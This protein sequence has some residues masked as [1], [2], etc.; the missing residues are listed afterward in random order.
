MNIILISWCTI[1]TIVLLCK[2][3]RVSCT[4]PNQSLKNTSDPNNSQPVSSQNNEPPPK[5]PDSANLSQSSNVTLIT[6]NIDLTESTDQVVYEHDTVNKA[7]RWTCKEGFLIE[8][9]T[10]E[11]NVVW[12]DDVRPGDRVVIRETEDGLK[13]KVYRPGDIEGSSSKAHA[14]QP[15]SSTPAPETAAQP[16]STTPTPPVATPAPKPTEATPV[17]QASAATPKPAAPAQPVAQPVS[18]TPVTKPVAQPVESTPGSQVSATVPT[19]TEVSASQSVSTKQAGHSSPTLITVAFELRESTNQIN[20]EFDADNKAHRLKCKDGFLIEKVTK[21]AN[22]VWQDDVRPGD[23][24][25]IRETEDG[26]KAKVYRPG[27]IE[28]SSSKAHAQQ[29]GSSTPAPETAAQPVSTTPTPPVATP[30]PKP[31][32]ATPVAQASAATPKPAPEPAQAVSTQVATP[33]Q[34]DQVALPKPV[35]QPTAQAGPVVPSPQPVS[36]TP[37]SSTPATKPAE[38]TPVSQAKPVVSTPAA[39][40]VPGTPEAGQESSQTAGS[41]HLITVN[42]DL[43]ESTDQVV[44]EHD[45]VNK[46]QRWTCKEGFLIEKVTK[47]GNVVWQP[48]D[49][50]HG[51]RV[52]IRDTDKGPKAKVYRPGETEAQ[53]QQPGS[54]TPAPE[55]AAQPV[56]TTPTP[57]VAT[58]APK[59]TEATPVAQASAATP[60]PAAPAQPVAQPVSSTPVTKPVAQPVESTPGSQVSATVPTK[61]EVSASQSVST[62]QA[63]HSSPT[64]ITVAF[65]LRE[66]TNQINYEFDA[67][68]KAHRLKCKDGFLIEKV[69]KEANVVWQDDVRPGDRVVI[70]ETEDGLKA[71]VYRPGDIEGSSSKA[72]ARQVST[73]TATPKEPDQP[74]SSTPTP[75]VATPAPKPTEATPV[76]QASAATPKPAPEPA[77]AVST[78]VAT[79]KQPDQVALPKPVAQPTAQAGPVVPSPQPVSTTP[80][81][82]TPATKPA[83]ATP[84]SQAKPVVSTPAAKPVPGTPEA[85]QEAS[86]TIPDT[87]DQTKDKEPEQSSVTP[88]AKEPSKSVPATPKPAVS[89]QSV[90]TPS[91]SM[92][93]LFSPDPEDFVEQ[94]ASPSPKPESSTPEAKQLSQQPSE[95]PKAKEPDTSGTTPKSEADVSVPSPSGVSSKSEAVD[96]K[97]DPKSASE[98]APEQSLSQQP[99]SQV[100][101]ELA[102]PHEETKPVAQP[103]QPSEESKSVALPKEEPKSLT[104]P[105]AETKSVSEPVSTTPTAKPADKPA[106]VTPKP[107]ESSPTPLSSPSET[108]ETKESS[109]KPEAKETK[110]SAET[111]K[112]DKPPT[113]ETVKKESDS[114]AQASTE[115]SQSGVSQGFLSTGSQPAPSSPDVKSVIVSPK[116]AEYVTK[117]VSSTHDTKESVST[118][119]MSQSAV[120][121][122][123][124]D[125]IPISTTPAKPTEES[126]SET[127][128][129]EDLKPAIKPVAQASVITPKPV[130]PAS[131][132]TPKPVTPASVITPKPETPASVITPKPAA[133]PVSTSPITPAPKSETESVSATDKPTEETEKS[134]LTQGFLSSSAS[135]PEPTTGDK[136]EEHQPSGLSQGFL[137]T[138]GSEESE[139]PQESGL[140]EGFLGSPGGQESEPP[141]PEVKKLPIQLPDF[142]LPTKEEFDICKYFRSRFT[143]NPIILNIG[144]KFS[145]LL[146]DYTYKDDIHTFTAK[147]VFVFGWVEENATLIWDS[148]EKKD[149]SEKVEVNDDD[150]LT[151][152]L[153]DGKTRVFEKD[154]SEW[155]EWIQDYE[156]EEYHFTAIQCFGRRVWEYD[157]GNEF[158]TVHMSRL[159][160]KLILTELN[161]DKPDFTKP[162]VD[163]FTLGSEHPNDSKRYYFVKFSEDEGLFLFRKRTKCTKVAM[164][165][166]TIWNHYVS[167]YGATYP[168]AVSYYSSRE[169]NIHFFNHILLLNKKNKVWKLSIDVDGNVLTSSHRRKFKKPVEEVPPEP[170]PE[171]VPEP[172][173]TPKP[174][175]LDITSKNPTSEITYGTYDSF[176]FNLLK[177][178]ETIIW[179]T[180]VHKEYATHVEHNSTK[181]IV[182]IKLGNNVKKVFK[183]SSDGVWDLEL[184]RPIPA[185]TDKATLS[186]IAFKKSSGKRA[187]E[188]DIDSDDSTQ[189]FVHKVHGNPTIFTSKCHTTFKQVNHNCITIWKA[190]GDEC[191]NKVEF[192]KRSSGKL[193]VTVILCDGNKRLFVKDVTKGWMEIDLTAI[194]LY[195][196]NVMYEHD[197]YFYSNMLQ[198]STRTFEARDGF[199]F[200]HVRCKSGNNWFDIWKSVNEKQYATKVVNEN[201]SKVTVHFNIGRDKVFNRASDGKW[202]EEGAVASPA[203]FTV[204]IEDDS[205]VDT[206]VDAP[207]DTP[208]DAPVDTHVDAPVDTTVDAPVDTTVDTSSSS[209]P[210]EI[211]VSLPQESILKRAVAAKPAPVSVSRRGSTASLSEFSD[212]ESIASLPGDDDE[213]FLNLQRTDITIV[214]KDAANVE[215]TNDST[216]FEVEEDDEELVYSFKDPNKCVEVKFKDKL[217]WKFDSSKNVHPKEVCFVLFTSF[218]ILEFDDGCNIKG[219]KNGEFKSVTR[220]VLKN[221]VKKGVE[222]DSKSK[223]T[224]ESQ[225]SSSALSTPLRA[226]AGS[227]VQIAQPAGRAPLRTAIKSVRSSTPIFKASALSTPAFTDVNLSA[228]EA[229]DTSGTSSSYLSLSKTGVDLDILLVISTSEFEHK[230]VDNYVTYS[231][232]ANHAFKTVKD[233]TTE[234]WK[235]TDANNY[236]TKVEVDMPS[237]YKAVTVFL[238]GDITKVFLKDS[239]TGKWTA[240]DTYKVNPITLNVNSNQTTYFCDN[241]LDNNVRTFTA[242][243]GFRFNEVNAGS[244]IIKVEIWKTDKENEY[245]NKVVNESS[246]KLTIHIGEGANAST[247]VFNKGSDGKWVH[248]EMTLPKSTPDSQP[249]TESRPSSLS[250]ALG[251]KPSP[252]AIGAKAQPSALSSTIRPKPASQPSEAMSKP[253]SKPE[254]KSDSSSEAADATT[255]PSSEAAALK[256]E[257]SS[258]APEVKS[259]TASQPEAKSDPSTESPAD[260]TVSS[261]EASEDK[262]ESSSEAAAVK[263]ATASQPE[264]KSETPSQPEEKSES[265]TEAPEVKTVP[266]SQPEDKSE[267]V[268]TSPLSKAQPK[269]TESSTTRTPL[270]TPKPASTA[271]GSTSARAS[272]TTPEST[273]SLATPGSTDTRS[274]LASE[275]SKQGETDSAPSTASGTDS[276]PTSGTGTSGS[277]LTGTSTY[278]RLF[279]TS[280]SSPLNTGTINLTAARRPSVASVT[281]VTSKAVAVKIQDKTENAKPD[282]EEDE[283]DLVTSDPS[284]SRVLIHSPSN[285]QDSQKS[286]KDGEVSKED[287]TVSTTPQPK[288]VSSLGSSALRG[289]TTAISATPANIASAKPVSSAGSTSQTSDS[290]SSPIAAP[291]TSTPLLKLSQSPSNSSLTSVSSAS[292]ASPASGVARRAS[293]TPASPASAVARRASTTPAPIATPASSTSSEPSQATPVATA[294][295]P[296]VTPIPASGTPVPRARPAGSSGGPSPSGIVIPLED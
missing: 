16:V 206:P 174:V 20:Y 210:C 111:K 134:G 102:K 142:E 41:P 65:E 145:T 194:N 29:P 291:S 180:D 47:A 81:S 211:S 12:Q 289:S 49:G 38:A 266:E 251:A 165:G 177:E 143:K 221:I 60:K 195:P 171:P 127:Q 205:P 204:E 106:V 33:K 242:K 126:N 188:L 88:E 118:T 137:S 50:R 56:S 212:T 275:G 227:I 247:K 268:V 184:S 286:D 24:V 181:G 245:A 17:A 114:D 277:T 35:A 272:S 257:P 255:E 9:V 68:N 69:T 168:S 246:N 37:A 240:I 141:Q 260:K 208:V 64:L 156:Y 190:S 93:E 196:M 28:G 18:S 153:K 120:L 10:K 256:T 279:E 284:E 169:V 34:P 132:I 63:G 252:L 100:T 207:V 55:T 53:D 254:D 48:K 85:G 238:D 198:G 160:G 283:D 135:Q 87:S 163:V 259:A 218:V 263:S 105:T 231:A 264:P 7:Q 253:E 109:E 182:T 167:V 149:Y 61:T 244:G 14:Q 173:P 97:P 193:D 296:S 119:P 62:K 200:N 150:V 108:K 202:T 75:P 45:T 23:R 243:K 99:A 19:K 267:S 295:R 15:G 191:A 123:K 199:G 80:A 115:T 230:K 122:P 78:Q 151:V 216:K 152:Y 189:E 96:Q 274:G 292:T 104:Q 103:A 13:A 21:E 133:Q 51:D 46:A 226:R 124:T 76:A 164:N 3:D 265:S 278:S 225:R 130:T 248:V 42:I 287:V 229:D 140:S 288:A 232:K 144:M 91:I 129:S 8:K 4:D 59:P 22:V 241:I 73:Q 261:S 39:K 214:T 219:L 197:T 187:V 170:E 273:T 175:E 139:E 236:S 282:D 94:P 157:E 233:G 158:N 280:A 179:K 72:H 138:S 71:K 110:Q 271:I 66:S 234:V 74:V 276:R 203:A 215:S 270:L 217:V 262:S 89:T 131:V 2:L 183:R 224:A 26:L 136:S 79:P 36:T 58:P 154:G 112:P 155:K 82:S 125:A 293:V 77:Q 201:Q 147:E 294:R 1:V 98:P 121:T 113:T 83:E 162:S 95:T 220:S 223:E 128:S 281:S 269:P 25:V 44:Y 209:Q 107:A 43:T 67:D 213:T 31:T 32:E 148:G 176:G 11:A 52:V 172:E 239:Q 40:P 161:E 6:V 186:S 285:D 90:F 117:P 235:A 54:S 86:Q 92:A 116:P 237:N 192:T 27:D 250:S 166:E 258:V 84:V 249:S 222:E 146:F 228:S 159:G 5:P 185:K 101:K 290:P 178:H 70:R 30:A 57:P